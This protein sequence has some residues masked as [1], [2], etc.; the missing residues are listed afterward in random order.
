MKSFLRNCAFVLVAVASL[1]FLLGVF[2]KKKKPLM[3]ELNNI[4]IAYGMR[5]IENPFDNKIGFVSPAR[6]YE[7]PTV[8]LPPQM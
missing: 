2:R 1:L 4:P 7:A 6:R 3:L 8:V 5:E